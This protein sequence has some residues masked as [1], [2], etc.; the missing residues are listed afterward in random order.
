MIAM[1]F[2]EIKKI[3]DTQNDRPLYAIDEQA[4]H[5]SITSKRKSGSQHSS[6]TEFGLIG[7]SLGT[8]AVLLLT[9]DRG[10]YDYLASAFLLGIAGYIWMGRIRRRKQEERFDRTMLGELDHAIA[11]AEFELKRAKTFIWW[12]LA[13]LT[14]PIIY[15]FLQG[16]TPLWKWFVVPGSFVLAYVVVR[17]SITYKQAPKVRRLK[18]LREQL[19]EKEQE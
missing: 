1:K 14:I 10:W 15:S 19:T 11:N 13:P 8:I 2:E 16:N 3:W 17:A 9:G 7:V 6:L 12:Y 5:R 18:Q 4:M